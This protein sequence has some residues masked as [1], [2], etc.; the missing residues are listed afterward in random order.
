MTSKCSYTWPLPTLILSIQLWLGLQ[1]CLKAIQ[2]Q[3]WKE[4]TVISSYSMS[5]EFSDV[6]SRGSC[7]NFHNQAAWH[8]ESSFWES[9]SSSRRCNLNEHEEIRK[10][11]HQHGLLGC[12]KVLRGAYETPRRQDNWPHASA[13]TKQ[14]QNTIKLGKRSFAS[15]IRIQ[16]DIYPNQMKE[17]P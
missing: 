5:M 10:T 15:C 2:Q 4:N 11:C 13:T 3:N 12:V 1:I 16:M 7:W 8:Q 9:K 6:Q 17:T 14:T